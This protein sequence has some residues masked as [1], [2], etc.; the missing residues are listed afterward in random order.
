MVIPVHDEDN[1]AR[2]GFRPWVVWSLL[3]VNVL[4]LAFLTLLTE[5]AL[6]AIGYNFGVVPAFLTRAT[7]TP[8]TGLLIWPGVTLLTYMF[9]HASWL[10]LAANMIFLWVLGDDVEAATGHLRFLVF[11][12]LCGIAG[13]FAQVISEPGSTAPVIGA[14]GA[15]AG[16]VG[17]Y[18]LLRPY[19]RMTVLVLGLITVRLCAYWVIAFWVVWQ[20]FNVWWP[21]TESQTAYWSHAGGFAAGLLLVL[22]MRKK[23]VALFA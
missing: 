19:A 5:Q 14:S 22:I 9:L 17:A 2:R 15:V 12:L 13:A 16:I 1:I 18:L 3:V 21:L 20:A 23:G 6:Y 8:V 4:V 11:Y 7:D 10:H